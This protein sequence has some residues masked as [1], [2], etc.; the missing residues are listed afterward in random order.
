[1]TEKLQTLYGACA[2]NKILRNIMRKDTEVKFYKGMATPALVYR[3][4]SRAQNTA[5]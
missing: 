4:K 3:F 2:V 5:R 1:M